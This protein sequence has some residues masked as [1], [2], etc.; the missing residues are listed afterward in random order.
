MDESTKNIKLQILSQSFYLSST[1]RVIAA[2]TKET[3]ISNV[4]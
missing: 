3:C 2:E 1:Q 4:A